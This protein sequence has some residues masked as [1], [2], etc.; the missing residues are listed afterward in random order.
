MR[1]ALF[2]GHR[3]IRIEARPTP[4]PGPG[5]VLV[6][7]R[8]AGICGSDL[9]AYRGHR[10][11]GWPVPW[12]Q[13]HELA[14]EVAAVGPGVAALA[15]G[16]RVGI[17]AEH[18][19]GCGTCRWCRQGQSHVCP[20]R[21]LVHGAR[22]A[23]HGFSEYDVTLV[24]NCH[25]LPDHVAFEAGALL[26]C[27]ACGVHALH[28]TPAPPAGVTVIVGAGAIALTLGQVARASGAG[29]VIMVGT[30]PEPLA[31]A[32]SAGA[33][34]AVVVTAEEDPVAA[35]RRATDGAGADVVFETVGGPTPLLGPCMEMAAPGGAVVVLGVF[36]EPQTIPAQAQG[37]AK[38]LRLVWSNSYSTWRGVS[39][40][41]TALDLVAAGR[42]EPGPLVTHRFSQARIG[43]AFAAA[44]DK[45]RS[46]AIKV[47]VE[48]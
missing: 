13:G 33:A 12:E 10:D 45:R 30:R 44:D 19:V 27:Y 38:E 9:H 17:E 20:R 28:R 26:D 24:A 6:R 25:R 2:Y 21:G 42:V 39:E 14:G 37:M 23:S 31:V 47:I 29:W 22:H 36:T 15:P 11:P 32:R 35:V 5:E 34:D 4:V 46:G 1:A 8:A 43:E 3:D 40:Y 48:P 41:R 18:L 16:D 7:V